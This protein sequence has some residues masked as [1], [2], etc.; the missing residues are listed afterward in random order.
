MTEMLSEDYK[1]GD[2]VLA[3]ISLGGQAA[4]DVYRVI[5][6]RRMGGLGLELGRSAPL[7]AVESLDNRRQ[8]ELH[9]CELA[10]APHEEE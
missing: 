10:R 9:A 5:G 3:T 2:L 1:V 6:I 7:Y 8:F 4:A